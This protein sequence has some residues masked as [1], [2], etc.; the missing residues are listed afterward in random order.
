MADTD[1]ADDKSANPSVNNSQTSEP[2]GSQEPDNKLKEEYEVLKKANEDLTFV[3]NIV[4]SDDELRELF[5]KKYAKIT[6]VSDPEPEKKEEKKEVQV[7]SEMAEKLDRIEKTQS[8]LEKTQ[9][10]DVISSFEKRYGID[11]LPEEE[12]K[13]ARQK[14]EMQLGKWGHSVKTSPVDNLSDLLGDA[15]NVVFKEKIV[16]E[17]AKEYAARQLENDYGTMG[18]FGSYR[19]NTDSEKRLT[20]QQQSWAK[21]LGVDPDKAKEHIQG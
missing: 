1:N 16:E 18:T 12:R 13:A 6:G 7:D 5:R 20:P 11:Q 17:E 15:Y 14:L 4:A 3:A 10:G 9:R 2:K 8:S 19:A 21:R